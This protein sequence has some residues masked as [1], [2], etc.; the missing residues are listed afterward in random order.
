MDLMICFQCGKQRPLKN[1]LCAECRGV[2]EAPVKE[3]LFKKVMR[4]LR[5]NK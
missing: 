1:G 2:K 5:L 3:S 4:L